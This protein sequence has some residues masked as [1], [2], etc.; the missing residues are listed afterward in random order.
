MTN[1]NNVRHLIKLKIKLLMCTNIISTNQRIIISQPRIIVQ[2]FCRLAF[3]KSGKPTTPIQRINESKCMTII[4]C[5]TETWEG[6]NPQIH[7]EI[8]LF[9]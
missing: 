1:T 3:G 2:I 6:V 8:L 4:H 5:K 7:T 9:W